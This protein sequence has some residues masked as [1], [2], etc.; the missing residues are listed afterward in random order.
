MLFFLFPGEE[1]K[2]KW[3]NLRDSYAKH[4]KSLKTTTGQSAKQ[5]LYKWQWAQQMEFFR[6]YMTFANTVSNVTDFASEENAD[7]E[8]MSTSI[9]LYETPESSVS[10]KTPGHE[11]DTQDDVAYTN[12]EKISLPH[13][14]F[15]L[16]KENIRSSNPKRAKGCKETIESPSATDK[17]L[18]Y[19]KEKHFSGK[20]KKDDAIDLIFSGYAA[21]IIKF[22]KRMQI[23]AKLKFAQLMAELELENEQEK[24][25]G[26]SVLHPNNRCS[27]R[28]GNV[29]APLVSPTISGD[30]NNSTLNTQF[31]NQD[32]SESSSLTTFFINYASNN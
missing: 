12:T 20:E 13:E 15:S 24:A 27:S 18:N 7:A 9:R 1:L 8:S 6:L 3:K 30:T 2:K 5:K 29:S 22:S 32:D 31:I 19:L 21:T 4:L 16:S 25:G 28:S 26:F 14:S 11:L 10:S 23:N 17:V